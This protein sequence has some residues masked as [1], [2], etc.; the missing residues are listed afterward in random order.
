[1]CGCEAGRLGE[2][3]CWGSCFA[4][5]HKSRPRSSSRW[6]TGGRDHQVT[7]V[8]CRWPPRGCFLSSPLEMG[9]GNSSC[10]RGVS[11]AAWTAV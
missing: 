11:Q 3:T 6:M 9:R 8:I 5:N 1:M 7:R 4:N 2:P 10:R